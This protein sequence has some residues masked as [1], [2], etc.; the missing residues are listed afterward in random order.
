MCRVTSGPLYR[1]F[2]PADPTDVWHYR[3]VA[4]PVAPIPV[5]DLHGSLK[6]GLL[7][8][9]MSFWELAGA[10]PT[11]DRIARGVS[12][13]LAAAPDP[14]IDAA[15]RRLQELVIRRAETLN[16][17]DWE[18]LVV[19]YFKAQGAA[20]DERRVGGNRL[21][22]DAEAKFDHGEFGSELWRVQVKH[23]RNRPVDGPEI[24]QDYRKVGEAKFC[25]VS[26]F[27]FTAEARQRADAEGVR[28]LE[29][30]DFVRFL[31]G[32]KLRDRLRQKLQLP[33]WT[34]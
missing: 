6:G 23:Y 14:E 22:I 4:Y 27:G 24:E 11:V 25:F 18:W 13:G 19:D 16:E 10:Y 1:D 34:P 31:L 32:G 9:R 5:L 29:A 8:P 12:P 28:L 7:G 26:V 33:V 17:Q 20:V 21:I 30:G 2:D 15:Y 3:R